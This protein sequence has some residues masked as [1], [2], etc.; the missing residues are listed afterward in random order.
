MKPDHAFVRAA[1]ARD[2]I[3]A[4]PF[5]LSAHGV[6]VA[7]VR[8]GAG[9]RAFQGR[10]P[11]QGALL[12]EG[13]IDGDKLVCRNHRWRFSLDSGRRDGGPECLA[14]CP[15][16]ERDGAIFI[17]VSALKD[18]SRAT[19]GARSLD[20]LP[21]PTPLPLLG[22]AHQIDIS[23]AHLILEGWARQY[24]PTFKFYRGRTRVVVTS[25]AT[26]INEA[27][28][29]RPDTF[30]RSERTDETFSE[31]GIKGVFNAEG[32]AWRSQR[33]LA[34]A[35]LAQRSLKQLY[36]HIE[37]IAARLKRRWERA[38][39]T[40]EALDLVDEM[41]RF[42]VDVTMLIAFGH[43]AN[44]VEATNDVIQRHLEIILPTVSRRILAVFPRWRYIKLSSDRRLDEALVAANE[45][46]A[47]LVVK[48]RDQLEAS[49]DKAN[50]PANFL[51]SMVVAVDENGKAYSDATIMSNLITMLI[52]GEDTTAFTLAWAV[53]ELCDKPQWAEALRREADDICGASDV[54]R[55]VDVVN[56][57]PIA[58]AI[59]NETLRL[60][61]VA[62]FMGIS[63]NIDTSLG[64]YFVPKGT[65]IVLLL[66][67]QALDP[68]NF[69]DPLA[70]RPERWLEASSAPHDPSAQVP[71]G[72]GPRMCPG[73][74]LALLEIKSL[75]SMM[76]KN[77]DVERAG[78]AEDV[79]ELF[80]FT[81]S[82]AGLKVRFRPR[83][84]H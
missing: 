45:W 28:S 61:P 9:W 6:D 38:A 81:M 64:G 35:A 46:L 20:E 11:H 40:G 44:T 1:N 75:L 53:H 80:G 3:G 37:T 63:A 68:Q 32:A 74:S 42:T 70:F 13:E 39:A 73:R 23:K 52:A 18:A 33:K 36:P 60:R 65:T 27:L 5:A 59:A 83:P 54:A 31:V 30:K 48:T 84:A 10:C 34:A 4:G 49:P 7:L 43:D 21:G 47:G 76:Y 25:D 2:L 69:F 12:G 22:N 72:A 77:F 16:A 19:A 62:P 78:R 79:T 57:L 26:M 15:V 41:K 66:R 51:E 14:S 8:T 71:F 24:G 50:H 17:D 67:P 29:A 58:G 56:R 82:P 55:D